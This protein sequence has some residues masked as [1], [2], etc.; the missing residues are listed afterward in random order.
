MYINGWE[1]V[2]NILMLER[3]PE[4]EEKADAVIDLIAEAQ[5]EDGY[6]DTYF[7]IEEPDKKMD[8]C[9]GMP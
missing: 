6:L 4:L 9:T 2:G 5:E 8:E 7:S 1:A 3:N